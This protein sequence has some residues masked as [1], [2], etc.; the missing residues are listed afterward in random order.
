MD[1]LQQPVDKLLGFDIA[2]P[3]ELLF[4]L[5]EAI[6]RG[7]VKLH[8]WQIQF[9]IDFANQMNTKDAPFQAEVQAANGSGKD[10]YIVAPCVVWLCMRYKWARGV[11]TN[12]SGVQLDNQTETYIR[13]LCERANT[14]F[15]K[16]TWKCN[17][18]YYEC[19]ETNSPIVLFATDEPTK[20]EGY[21]PL[22]AGAKLAIFASEA[23]AI[24]D[25]IFT[26]LKR[27]TGVTHRIDVS[28]PGLP[29]GFFFNSCMSAVPRS[30]LTDIKEVD[31]AT[32]LLYKVTYKDCSH[33]T[34]AEVASFVADF[35]DGWN[36]AV[37]K[38]ALLAEF[39]TTDEMVVIPTGFIFGNKKLN[40]TIVWIK[41]KHNI[42]GLD[43]SDGGA[44]S[45]L[46]IRNGNK[47]IKTIAFRFDNTEDTVAFL[48]ERFREW[49]LLHEE[50]FIFGDCCGIGKPI[51]DRLKRKGWINIKYV[52]SRSNAAQPRVYTN[53]GT[54]LFFNIRKLLECQAIILDL[55]KNPD[56]LLES[57]LT[58]RFYK[59]TADNKHA[60]LSKLEQ[61]SRGFLSPDRADSLNL[62]FWNYKCNVE[63]G[64]DEKPFNASKPI[65]LEV[66]N[67]F[68]LKE[69]ASRGE[70][71]FVPKHNPADELQDEITHFNEQ[72]ILNR[73][74]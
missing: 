43:L 18:R 71:K 67:D 53:R 63:L 69:W 51:L 3:V 16:N 14:I 66:I 57:Q 15:G 22:V 52:D 10:K 30:Q 74:N 33:I 36:N 17:Y 48:E 4:I 7:D 27:C 58:S 61:R 64:K 54:E 20:A 60:L 8:P 59:I 47:R 12:G 11:A 1:T 13:M 5:D 19:L 29:V 32:K 34:E 26:A 38:S 40:D 68:D 24:P 73:K 6:A 72:L 70:K 56:K 9:M 55:N 39:G 49:E 65:Q 25:D 37:V 46:T 42:A 45:V 50:A 31:S 23:K 62:C 28:T 44:E 35:P 2:N 41:E 21:H